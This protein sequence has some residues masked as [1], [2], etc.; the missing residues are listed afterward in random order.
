MLA[1]YGIDVREDAI[2]ALAGTTT[3]GT[4]T[5]GI[6]KVLEHYN[7]SYIMGQMHVDKIKEA[8]DNRYPVLLTLQ[9]YKTKN[10]PYAECWDDG[11]YVVAIGYDER[12]LIFEDP[13]SYHRTFLEYQELA[14]RWHD[15]ESNGTKLYNWGCVIVGIPQYKSSKAARME[16]IGEVYTALP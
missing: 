12:R 8:I 16:F 6:S 5:K 1:Y 15:M 14:D 7:L 11:H 10:T 9:A 2:M 4:G 13:S 3:D